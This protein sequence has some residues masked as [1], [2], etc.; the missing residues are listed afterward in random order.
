MVHQCLAST[1]R[2]AGSQ[3]VLELR[4]PGTGIAS[5]DYANDRMLIA[6]KTTQ[7]KLFDM[8]YIPFSL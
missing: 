5:L 8:L 4:D 1:A 7:V 2:R 6:A 3:S